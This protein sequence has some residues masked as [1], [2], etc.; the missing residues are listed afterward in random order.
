MQATWLKAVLLGAMITLLSIGSVLG[1]ESKTFNVHDRVG[2]GWHMY[3]TVTMDSTGMILG[4]TTLK[5][6]NN[7]RGYTG[8]VFVVALDAS[9]EAIYASKV[10]KYGINASFF[11][12]KRERTATWDEQIPEEYLPLVSKLAVVQMH[13]PTNR[14]WKWIY[15]NKDLLVKHAFA[16]ADVVKDIQNDEFDMDDAFELIGD[17]LN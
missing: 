7:L 11:R 6:Y 14:V 4:T 13:T 12:K 2:N 15:N 8:G 1:Q 16:I 3:T 9:G 5:N 10:K 17:H